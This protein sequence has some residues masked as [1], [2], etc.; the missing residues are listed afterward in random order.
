[1]IRP[2]VENF[3]EQLTLIPLPQNLPGFDRFINAWLVRGDRTY[4]IDP[5][6]T[7]TIPVLTA[8][9][10]DLGVFR[11]DAIL[12]TH[13]HIDHSGGVGDLAKHFPDTKVVCHARAV[14]HL[15][16]PARL[17]AGSVATLGDTARA[18]G[19]IAP[20]PAEQVV[21]V[22]DMRTPGFEV[23]L[24]PGHAVH[25][26]SY[27]I[28]GTL[29]AGEASGVYRE[30]A[31]SYYL[32]PATPPKFYLETSLESIQAL[33]QVSCQRMCFGHFGLTRQPAELLRAHRRQLQFWAAELSRLLTE[34]G[35]GDQVAA[36]RAVLLERDPL[37]NGFNR[38]S[39]AD[40]QRELGFMANSVRGFL[41]YLQK[42]SGRA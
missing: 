25:H 14:E 28:N 42:S 29:F 11:L 15:V 17:W 33:A 5:G 40:Q 16:D 2:P 38:F 12:L 34:T 35:G 18:Y 19:P 41:G 8:A 22:E 9:L 39:D 10:R 20:V 26:V 31:G 30:L 24:T 32:R 37:L 7:V 27:L 3:G 23:I 6:P 13:I 36:G 4:L 21:A 1:M